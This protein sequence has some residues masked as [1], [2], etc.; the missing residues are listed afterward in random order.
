[1]PYI[2]R[3]AIL[4][5]L[6]LMQGCA[7]NLTPPPTPPSGAMNQHRIEH[8]IIIAID[9]LKRDTLMA[10]LQKA[11]GRRKGGL[12]DLFGVTADHASIELTK[13]IAV[14]QAV[15]V[16]PSFTY[17]S[18]TSMFTGVYPGAHGITGNNVFFRDR[19]VARYYTEYHVDAIR[20]QLDKNF[21]S[22]DI[23]SHIKTLYEFVQAAG[24]K[25]IVVH[26]MVSR[27]SNLVKPDFDTL[28]SYQRNHSQAV[29]ENTLWAAV[30]TLNTYKKSAEKSAATLPTVFTIYFSGLDHIEHLSVDGSDA[31]DARLDYIDHLDDLI[32]KFFVGH[33]A[34]ARNHF[35]APESE[36]VHT[37]T[38][39]WS[40]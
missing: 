6:G 26:N 38:I 40:G 3:F 12:H 37:D 14:Q 4:S 23:N 35:V 16:F 24:G 13:G 36:S 15:T 7:T 29:D 18:W 28:W 25:S 1:M 32:S 21:L 33:P 10:Y 20:A 22:K 30:D 9:G 31:E 39:A 17:P 2:L 34:I 27:G 5:I 19:E 8:V 11:V